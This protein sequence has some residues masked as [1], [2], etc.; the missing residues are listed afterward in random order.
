MNNYTPRKIEFKQII[1][2]PTWSVKVYTI[3]ELGSNLEDIICEKAIQ[4]LKGW[5]ENEELYDLH[6]EKIAFLFIHS[7]EVGVISVV[8][9]WYGLENLNTQIYL[10]KNAEKV[11]NDIFVRIP[12]NGSDPSDWEMEIIMHERKSWVKNVLKPKKSANYKT[13]LE[14]TYNGFF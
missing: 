7:T 2:L 11:D 13:Y 10:T 8:N 1:R 5:M 9:W 14:D 3:A 6:H 12:G 4:Y